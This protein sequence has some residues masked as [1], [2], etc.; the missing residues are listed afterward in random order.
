[1]AKIHELKEKF[2]ALNR[3]NKKTVRIEYRSYLRES[4]S[5]FFT[6]YILDN[7][8]VRN[9]ECLTPDQ[10]QKLVELIEPLYQFQKTNF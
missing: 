1:M 7:H 5:K 10:M 9:P 2:I 3:N 6:A 4:K 8:L